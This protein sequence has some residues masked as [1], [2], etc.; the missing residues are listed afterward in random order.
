MESSRERQWDDPSGWPGR[1]RAAGRGPVE[2]V[3]SA[4]TVDTN[5]GRL[6]RPG[7]CRTA[8]ARMLRLIGSVRRAADG[9]MCAQTGPYTA[10]SQ[11]QSQSLQAAVDAAVAEGATL[12]LTPGKHVLTEAIAV[13]SPAGWRAF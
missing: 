5:H 10:H 12:V 8:C 1:G 3:G 2:G 6:A 4:A 13:R 7:M 11:G 9:T